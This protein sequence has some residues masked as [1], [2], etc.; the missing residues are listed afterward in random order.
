MKNILNT[1]KK[2]GFTLIEVLV[3]SSVLFIVSAA[4]VGLSNSIIQ[5]T[6]VT[7]DSATANRLATEGLEL[8]TKIRDDKV[9]NANFT[10]GK[11]IWFDP[12]ELYDK[13]GW[14]KLGETF[15]G[16]NIW[17]LIEENSYNDPDTKNT[18]DLTSFDPQNMEYLPVDSID[19]YRL[20]C[21]EGV[22]AG[23]EQEDT[24][25]GC[26]IITIGGGALTVDDGD[27]DSSQ[28]GCYDPGDTINLFREDTFCLFTQNSLNK[29]QVGED[30]RI[31][32]G[33]AVKIRSVVIWNDK[34]TYRSTDI[35][36][37]LTNWQS[38]IQ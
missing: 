33:N 30:K 34:D 5:G 15:P 8:V 17:E 28:P 22:A 1:V 23:N 10:T 6:S 32:D 2:R 36:T 37:L 35:A 27:R 24:L 31:S 21:V 19:Y 3:A 7:A 25:L 38:F 16:N 11:F 14:Y 9:K 18:I 12:V 29:N 13:Y 4:V 20:I 26:N